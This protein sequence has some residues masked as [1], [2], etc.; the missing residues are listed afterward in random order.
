MNL[1]RLQKIAQ[2]LAH[3]DRAEFRDRLRQEFA[4]RQD[5]VLAR[6]GHDFAQH[7]R[8]PS[9][10]PGKFFFAPDAVDPILKL[11]RNSFRTTSNESSI[12]PNKSAGIAST[13]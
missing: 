13:C 5:A 6:V 8:G 1:Q 9:A 4:S 12:W 11:L 7:L 3:M 10:T 2:R